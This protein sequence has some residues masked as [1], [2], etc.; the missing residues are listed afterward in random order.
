MSNW[1][2]PV[3]ALV[4][5]I[6]AA[7]AGA[8]GSPDAGPTVSADAASSEDGDPE[9]STTD[10]DEVAPVVTVHR[11]ETCECCGGYEEHLEAEGF[12]VEVVYHDDVTA[13]K[14]DNDIPSE[15]RSCHTNEIGGYLAEGHVPV[16]A[17]FDL[18]A[19]APDA[20][21][22]ALAGMPSGSPGMP[23]EQEAPFV[24]ETFLDGTVTGELGRY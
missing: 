8:D 22:I 10:T 19:A 1:R 20:D 5:V 13:F 23:G 24:V 9:P 12:E 18:V 15:L 14:D 11:S 4:L 16:E 6:G 7:C 3:L 21:G 2:L 17:L